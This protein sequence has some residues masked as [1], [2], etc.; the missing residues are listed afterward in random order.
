LKLHIECLQDKFEE[1][2][3]SK[4]DGGKAIAELER[5]KEKLDKSAAQF[6]E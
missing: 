1:S 6:K 2:E 5:Y 4:S 3:K